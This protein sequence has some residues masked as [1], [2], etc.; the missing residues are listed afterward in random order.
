MPNYG[1]RNRG[2]PRTITGFHQDEVG[3][4]VA[5]LSCG[6]GQHVRHRPPW[7]MRPWV[8]TEKGRQE[9]L[10]TVLFCPKCETTQDAG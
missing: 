2:M 8:T 5:E 10:A 4:W 9:H 7:E 6:H 1:K 3:D